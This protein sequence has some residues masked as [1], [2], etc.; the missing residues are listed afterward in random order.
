MKISYR[1]T[2]GAPLAALALPIVEAFLPREPRPPGFELCGLIDNQFAT[3]PKL[4][5]L[6]WLGAYVTF[7]VQGLRNRSGPRWFAIAA[8]P[9]L[10][11]SVKSHW[12]WISMGCSSSR[13]TALFLLWVGMVGLMFLHHAVQPQTT[14]HIGRS[15]GS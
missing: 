6:V 10:F 7:T 13:N 11:L 1:L 9:A 8:L 3:M 2:S 15:H 4:F 5:A 14:F 12:W